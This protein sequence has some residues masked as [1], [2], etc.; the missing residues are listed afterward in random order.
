MHNLSF[1]SHWLQDKT[2]FFYY[3]YNVIVIAPYGL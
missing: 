1:K 2:T 3:D